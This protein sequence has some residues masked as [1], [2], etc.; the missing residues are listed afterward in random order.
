MVA[1]IFYL[2][3]LMK[4]ITDNVH[5]TDGCRYGGLM[6]VVAGTM[7]LANNLP[8]PGPVDGGG[9]ATASNDMPSV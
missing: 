4:I 5:L 2:N 9:P 1:C 7:S 3:V 6:V 8:A